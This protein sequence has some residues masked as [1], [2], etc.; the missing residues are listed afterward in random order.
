[1]LFNDLACEAIY[2]ISIRLYRTVERFCSRAQLWN[3][4]SFGMLPIGK[5]RTLRELET[6][7]IATSY[8]PNSKS[9]K[10]EGI[11]RK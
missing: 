9:I 11:L 3:K 1:M 7:E 10:R 6:K 8:E 4:E 2:D 5:I